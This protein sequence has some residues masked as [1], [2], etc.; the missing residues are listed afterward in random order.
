MI[1]STHAELEKLRT[2]LAG[3]EA[4]R[5]VLGDAILAPALDSLR[6]KIAA[7]Q[8]QAAPAEERRIVTILFSDIVGSTALAEKLDPEDWRQVVAAVHETAG[9]QVQK[10]GGTVLQY[11]GDGLLALFGVPNPSE[12]D[13]ENAIRA[14]LDIQ[15]EVGRWRLEVGGGES[16]RVKLP[17]SSLQSPTS[18]LHLRIGIH[19]GLVIVGELGSDAK[20]EF[21]AVGD[22]M[23]LAARLQSAAPPGGV[24]ISRDTYRHVRGI[25]DATAQPPLSVKGKSE[26]I[27]T[28]LVERARPRPFRAVTR[29]V[30]DV[31]TRTI[32]REAELSRLQAACAS[33]IDDRKLAWAQM[34]GQAGIGKSRLLGEM[35]E[36]IAL[37]P[38]DIALLKARAFESDEKQAFGLIRRV[39]LDRFRVAED[40]PLADAEAQWM[41]RF[42]R[43]R[44]AGHEE[45]AHALGLLVGLPFA[46][47][48]YIGA[49]RNDPA[50]V[51]GRAIVVSREFIAHLRQRMHVVIL[52]EDLHWADASSWDYL[53]QVVLEAEAAPHG[54]FVLATARPG[55]SPPRELIDHPDF[56]Q[57]EL[58]S[59]TDAACREL[60]QELLQRVEG[61]PGEAIRRVAERSEGVPYF[62][63]EIVNWFLDRGVIDRGREPWRFDAERLKESP[64]PATLQ[65]LLL[66]RLSA[67]GEAERVTLQRGSIFGRHFWEGGLEALGVRASASILKRLRP[68]NFVDEQPES[69]LADEREWSFHHNLLYETT[70]ESVLKRERKELHKAAAAWLEA[71][72][73]D[74]GRLDEFAGL[75]AE[76]AE[77]AGELG[78]AAEWYLRAGE[79]AKARGATREARRFFDHALEHLPPGD[80]ERRW[81]AWLGRHDVLGRLGEREEQETSVAMLLELAAELDDGRLAEAHYRHALSLDLS[82]GLREALNA[83][84]TALATARRANSLELEALLLSQKAIGQNRLG[85]ID[86]AAAAAR[87]ALSQAQQVAEAT[88]AKVLN[89]LAVYFVES[90]DLARA[91]QLHSQQAAVDRR[92]GD[93]GAEADALMN[94]GY[95]YVLMGMYDQGRAALEQ[96]LGLYQQIG[97][98][99][100]R[101]YALLNLGLAHWRSGDTRAAQQVL[102]QVQSELG[103]V[104]DTFGRAAGL[105]YL[106][107]ALEQAGEVDSAHRRFERA[108]DLFIEM[109]V[110]GYGADASA[111]LARCARAQGNQD[112]ARRRADEVWAHL[113]QHGSQGME[114]PIRAYLTCAEIFESLDES[115]RSHAAVEEG[116]RDLIRRAQ[117]ISNF[118]WGKSFLENVPEHRALLERWDRIAAP[119]PTVLT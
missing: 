74:A 91:A 52:L 106:A 43:F 118:E 53:S 54:L 92:L 18:N 85:E 107:L 15:L 75:L 13:P 37:R 1:D 93:R 25:F 105:S 6:E 16:D 109:G 114:F 60:V 68:R 38:E 81:R 7:L 65:H 22:A 117:K 46:D 17:S 102:E 112:E 58:S 57:I 76:H 29:G 44:G 50:Q 115:N 71:H 86:G 2:A 45:A 39:W 84:D 78:A 41:E 69:W 111:G 80:R 34:V 40:A 31:E 33:A 66:T 49:M 104:G 55:W 56:V 11:L 20:R 8:A 88:A 119:V 87:E 3:L 5:A 48:P 97:N 63:E 82:G 110:H 89:N 62:A 83:Y 27:Q 12:S 23:N 32:G 79:G 19:T 73:R 103:A 90:G 21:T 70:Y 94:L 77:R 64:L 61:V 101:A 4:Q 72:A 99:R 10:H 14:A 116:Y 28:Y 47:S 98:R 96:S 35:T 24:L 30:A 108:R 95:D 26:P 67:L 51:K 36:Y 59:L 9:G 42:L 100:G 113:Q